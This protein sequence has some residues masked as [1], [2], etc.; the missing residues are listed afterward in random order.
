MPDYFKNSAAEAVKMCITG[1]IPSIFC[2]I[3]LTK[4]IVSSGFIYLISK[5]FGKVFTKLTGLPPFTSGV[6]LMSFLSGFPAGAIAA[7]DLYKN[8]AITKNDAERLIAISNNT[9]PALPVLLI[10]I[11][12]FSSY[13]IGLVIFFIQ[14]FSSVICAFVFKSDSKRTFEPY[15]PEMKSNAL[16]AVTDSV[17]GTIKTT[18]L[19]CAYVVLFSAVNDLISLAFSYIPFTLNL[20][21]GAKPFVEIVSGSTSIFKAMGHAAFLYI[22]PALSFGGLCVHM[23][24]VSVCATHKLSLKLHFKAKLLQSLIAF[25]LSLCYF[26]FMPDF[27]F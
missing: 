26:L 17:E 19:L 9:G 4:T 27:N 22:C 14:I 13:H 11:N 8:N 6:Y 1:V 12:L 24:T 16:R 2:F 3:V 5:P 20:L 23:Q 15:Y 25:I 7:A 10:G 21:F 18:S